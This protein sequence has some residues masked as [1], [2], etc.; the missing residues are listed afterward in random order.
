MRLRICVVSLLV[1]GLTSFNFAQAE[2]TDWS[3]WRGASGSGSNTTSQPP[4]NWDSK[5]NIKW[6]VEMP[7][8]GA[9][10][11]IISGNQVFVLTAIKTD[12]TA[13]G[14]AANAPE[15]SAKPNEGGGERRGGRPGGRGGFGGM[16]NPSFTNFYQFALISYDR[17]SGKELWRTVATEAVPHEPGH[18]T[19][20]LAGSSPVTDGKHV[21]VNFGSRGIFCFDMNGKKVWEKSYGQMQTRAEFGEG[22]SPAL[23]GDTLIVPWDHE[24][25]SFIVALDA[26]TGEEKWRR[27]RDERT[28]WSTPL[29]VEHKGVVQ[30]IA[31]GVKI[32]SYDLATG[33][34]IWECGDQ[35]DNPIPTP[36]LFGDHV[37]VMT[38]YR[39]DVIQSISLD[40][41][42]DVTGAAAVAWRRTDMAP[43]VP[44]P[45]LYQDTLYFTKQNNAIISAISAVNGDVIL[46]PQR[47]P[48]IE[49]LYASPIAADGRIYFTGRDGTTVAIKQGGEFEVLATNKIE[50]EVDASLALSG[51]EIFLR[52]ESHLYCIGE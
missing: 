50:E 14:V 28:T 40:A 6:K 51:N 45:V 47:L 32:R 43:Y 5:T 13:D 16:N 1:G 8:K 17:Q 27:D 4:L 20:T 15:D 42:G 48:G 33:D 3:Q 23:Y 24:G 12:R 41:K 39:G 36:V 38:G 7:G 44:T 21:F 31:N 26:N 29:I 9:S 46:K 22:S 49:S 19:N 2:T 35:A 25:P 10:T 11:P 37:I 34:L 52:S 30:V 18:K